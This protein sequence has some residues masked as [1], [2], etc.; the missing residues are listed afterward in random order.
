MQYSIVSENRVF[1]ISNK[2]KYHRES[3]LLGCALPTAANAI[4]NVA[5]INKNSRVLI[6]G[7]GGLGYSS[8]LVL[9]FI[10]CKNIVCIDNNAK[11][12][13]LISK[14]KNLTF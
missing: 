1:R 4:L 2:N 7:M 11:R 10:K 9:N 3:T 5:K 13:N 6:M 8:L 12:L 14:S